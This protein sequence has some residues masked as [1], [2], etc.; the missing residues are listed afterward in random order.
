VPKVSDADKIQRVF[1]HWRERTGHKNARLLPERA[2]KI[3]AR[4]KENFTVQDLC[5][6]VDGCL[7]SDYHTGKNEQG[8]RYDWIETIL[9]DG[10]SVE[11]HAARVRG[12]VAVE[13]EQDTNPRRAALRRAAREAM[14]AGN[15]ERANELNR[16]LGKLLQAGTGRDARQDR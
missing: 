8:E 5:N 4:L 12:N 13:E 16:E 14:E 6:A 7:L 3:R 11:K 2:R 15:V 10:T 1:H 9:R